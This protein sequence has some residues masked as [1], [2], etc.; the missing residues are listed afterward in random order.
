MRLIEDHHASIRQNSCIG[1][2]IGRSLDRQIG[3]KQMMVHDDDVALGG[4]P[5]HLGD[6]AAIELLALGAHTA[7][8]ARVELGPQMAVLRQLSQ[9]GAVARFGRLLP[10]ADNAELV[11]LFQPIQDRLAG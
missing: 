5:S 6:E 3:A 4:A 9:L 1:S 8:S 7:V 10:V 2:A 11:D